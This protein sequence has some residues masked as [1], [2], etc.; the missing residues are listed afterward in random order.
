M[1]TRKQSANAD[2]AL[3]ILKEVEK[4]ER[5]DGVSSEVGRAAG[6]TNQTKEYTTKQQDLVKCFIDCL[7]AKG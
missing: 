1:K 3:E 4:M 5:Q 2:S 6:A 7:A